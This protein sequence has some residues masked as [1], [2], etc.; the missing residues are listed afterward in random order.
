MNMKLSTIALKE[1]DLERSVYSFTEA[2]QTACRE[3]FKIINTQNKTKHKKSVLLRTES[4]I[5]MQNRVNALRRLYE[6]TRNN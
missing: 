1:N 2:L 3:G 6:R 4:L 5:N